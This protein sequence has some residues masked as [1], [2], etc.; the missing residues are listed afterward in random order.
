MN[1]QEGK[2][3]Y[4]ATL[5][6]A[7]ARLLPILRTTIAMIAGNWRRFANSQRAMAM[8]VIGG[9]MTSTLLTVVV[10]PVVF[11]YMDGWQIGIFNVMRGTGKKGRAIEGNIESQN[12]RVKIGK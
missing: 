11:T 6:S 10:I 2:P 9:L 5:D 4:E 7:V 8:A 3:M 12:G 1:Q